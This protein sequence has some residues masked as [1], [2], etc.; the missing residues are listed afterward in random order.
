M[1]WLDHYLV[2][3]G[4]VSTSPGFGLV[5]RENSN[6]KARCFCAVVGKVLIW[7]Q[8]YQYMDTA[9]PRIKSRGWGRGQCKAHN[10]PSSKNT[11]SGRWSKSEHEH[12]LQVTSGRQAT[13]ICTSKY[14]FC[15]EPWQG[16]ERFPREWKR[17]ALV[18]G[19]RTILQVRT[20]AQK[21][22]TSHKMEGNS[23]T[24]KRKWVHARA[25]SWV[26]LIIA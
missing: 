19:T 12:F 24:N 4:V 21:F 18:V 5:R 7:T 23:N 9:E 13:S 17:I 15:H 8:R 6:S 3:A 22:F 20:H 14:F 16:M 2:V 26:Q 1:L 11:N 10:E 25:H